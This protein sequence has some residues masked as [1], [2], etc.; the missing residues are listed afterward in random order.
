MELANAIL[1]YLEIFTTGNAAT[2]L[3]ACS[4]TGFENRSSIVI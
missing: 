4:P 3:L 2:A 1:E